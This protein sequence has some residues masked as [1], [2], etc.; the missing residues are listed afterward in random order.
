M[1]SFSFPPLSLSFLACPESR[2][3][4][5]VPSN[6]STHTHTHTHTHTCMHAHTHSQMKT[7][8]PEYAQA[9]FLPV[10]RQPEVEVAV[11]RCQLVLLSQLDLG[12]RHRR[13]S[14][15]STICFYI[16]STCIQNMFTHTRTHTVKENATNTDP[17]GIT[18]AHSRGGR[19]V[20]ARATQRKVEPSDDSDD[21]RNYFSIT[22]YIN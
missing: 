20:T 3:Q 8:L 19:Q 10:T 21:S 15:V 12:G 13:N 16:I 2:V 22:L 14:T 6:N 5:L 1:V 11:V 9:A 4:P 7:V 18:T 17:S